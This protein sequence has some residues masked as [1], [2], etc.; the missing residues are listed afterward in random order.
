MASSDL[1]PV[2]SQLS[3]QNEG[4]RSRRMDRLLCSHDQL[5]C[6]ERGEE[7]R[8]RGEENEREIVVII[9]RTC[10][11]FRFRRAAAWFASFFFFQ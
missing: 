11:A 2:G 6:A 7:E 9:S 10:L 5:S 1:Q 3:I 4:K 8:K